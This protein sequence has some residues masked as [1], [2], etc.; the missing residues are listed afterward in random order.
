[1][2]F[3]L[4][5]LTTRVELCGASTPIF[6]RSTW[7][8]TVHPHLPTSAKVSS[9]PA[10]PHQRHF[11]LTKLQPLKANEEEK[12]CRLCHCCWL[13]IGVVRCRICRLFCFRLRLLWSL[14]PDSRGGNASARWK[15]FCHWKYFFHWKYF[16]HCKYIPQ[17]GSLPPMSAEKLFYRI[18]QGT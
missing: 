9:H 1:M 5:A 13:N 11:P 4:T 6:Q 17:K 16:C 8:I 18:T 3:R 10:N 14:C 7:R 12:L 15:Y 2:H